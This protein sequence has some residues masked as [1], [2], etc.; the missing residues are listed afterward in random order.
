M[1]TLYERNSGADVAIRHK[2]QD[3]SQCFLF[4]F[5]RKWICNCFAEHRVFELVEQ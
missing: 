1:K 2:K 4:Y 3:Q 5:F